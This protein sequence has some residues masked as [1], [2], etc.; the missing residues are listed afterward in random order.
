MGSGSGSG[1]DHT[2]RDSD[3]SDAAA[4]TTC[5]G[6]AGWE[7]GDAG[8]AEMWRGMPGQ[9]AR[10]ALARARGKWES[11]L[12][13]R[14]MLK[15]GQAELMRGGAPQPL[16]NYVEADEVALER[17]EILLRLLRMMFCCVYWEN[18]AELNG[19]I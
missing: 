8:E 17:L 2:N 4:D 11:Q 18:I 5:R 13:V 16:L 12:A 14:R 6:G 3:P 19:S 9:R 1:T 15:E 7:A 10:A